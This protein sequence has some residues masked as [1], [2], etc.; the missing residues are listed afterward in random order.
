MEQLEQQLKRKKHISLQG[1]SKSFGDHMVLQEI[2]LEIEKGEFVAIVGKSGCGKSTL[3]RLIA[4]LEQVNKGTII[5]NGEALTQLNK[6][7]RM[8]FQDGRLL[9]WKRVIDNI[10]IAL[11]KE[12][13]V[14]AIET[15]YHVGL[16]DRRHDWPRNLSGGQKQRVAL[17]RALVHDPELLLL[18]EPLGALD[19]LTRIDMQELIEAL[20]NDRGFTAIL[21]THDVEEAVAIADRVLLIEEGRISLDQKINLPRPRRRTQIEFSLYVEEI[22]ARIMNRK[23][24]KEHIVKKP[25]QTV[26]V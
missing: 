11:S 18:D 4:G 12:K 14:K 1:V 7:A 2:D 5:M 9:P 20:W 16:A 17:A 26:S 3:L 22:L 19:A 10:Q 24:Y 13:E 6:Y 25:I 23:P 21:V 15:L 8:M